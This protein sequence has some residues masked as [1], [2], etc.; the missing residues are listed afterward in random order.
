MLVLFVSVQSI[1]LQSVL[2]LITCHANVNAAMQDKS[3]MTP[4]HVAATSDQACSHCTGIFHFIRC[5]SNFLVGAFLEKRVDYS[6]GFSSL[7][8]KDHLN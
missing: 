1:D 3:D 8:F 5:V 2:F 7:F 4:L 6:H